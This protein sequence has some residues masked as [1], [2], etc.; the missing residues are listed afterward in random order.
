MFSTLACL[1]LPAVI[2]L[3][4]SYYMASDVL[5][6]KAVARGL[7]ATK[8]IESYVNYIM[9][10]MLHASNYIQFDQEMNHSL[11]ALWNSRQSPEEWGGKFDITSYRKITDILENLSFSGESKYITILLPDGFPVTNYPGYLFNREVTEQSVWKERLAQL[12]HENTVWIERHP[13]YI[14]GDAGVTEPMVTVVRSLK[15]T[16]NGPNGYVFVSKLQSQMTS[17]MADY[18]SSQEVL[19]VNE[20]GVIISHPSKDKIGTVLELGDKAAASE[21]Q[22]VT[23]TQQVDKAQYVRVDKRL[24]LNGWFLVSLTPYQ[25]AVGNVSELFG[26]NLMFQGIFFAV[27]GVILV[28]LIGQFTKPVKRL[29]RIASQVQRGNLGLRS[30][31]SGRDEV[32]LLGVSFDKMLDSVHEM[33]EQVKLEQTHKRK[34]EL[35]L[36]QAQINPHFLFNILNSIRLRILMKGDEEIAGIISSLSSLLRMTIN[37]NN[38]FVTLHEEVTTVKHYV[39]LMRFRHRESLKLELLVSSDALL[40]EIPRFTLQPLVENSFLHGMKQYEGVLTI[41]AWLE[42]DAL[43]LQVED[44]GQGMSEYTVELLK[45]KLAE[46]HHAALES[47][48]EQGKVSG[49]GL[50]NVYERLRIQYG[51][52]FRMDMNS[53]LER[54]TTITF[55]IPYTARGESSVHNHVG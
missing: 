51:S 31:I 10:D 54:G 39:D 45:R 35:E 15:L 32:G 34:A 47:S 52:G 3:T 23:S 16:P 20:E 55:H 38:E 30:G 24:A 12:S 4:V 17:I 29:G 37:R 40:A 8:V 50:T 48:G 13:S 46:G 49:I 26:V 36:L 18:S 27:F 43:I 33:I 6:E 19:L 11:V 42:G 21:D 2:T 5:K 28:V 25:D 44:D 41:R 9:K 22:A 53:A 7:E 1:V 14:V